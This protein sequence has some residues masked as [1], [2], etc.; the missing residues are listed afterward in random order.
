MG[1]GDGV[2]VKRCVSCLIA[3]PLRVADHRVGLAFTVH[4]MDVEGDL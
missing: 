3:E 1:V 2:L 4:V